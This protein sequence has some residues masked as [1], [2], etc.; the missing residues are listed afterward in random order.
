[1]IA[2]NAGL[3]PALVHLQITYRGG[4]LELE[5]DEITRTQTLKLG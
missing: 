1:M 3:E 5:A 4:L 2:K